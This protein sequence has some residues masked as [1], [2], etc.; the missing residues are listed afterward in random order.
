MGRES[1]PADVITRDYT[2][3]LGKAITGVTFKKRA[4]RE[5][6]RR[7]VRA[8]ANDRDLSPNRGDGARTCGGEDWAR[9]GAREGKTVANKVFRPSSAKFPAWNV[10]TRGTRRE[11]WTN[12][13]TSSTT[14]RLRSSRK[15]R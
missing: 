11:R 8:N 6:S 13:E 5:R 1:K 7:C 3:N 9:E 12:L 15:R 2:I 14:R 10:A 4:R